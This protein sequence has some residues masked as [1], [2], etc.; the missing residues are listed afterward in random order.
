MYI[1]YGY[2]V[3]RMAYGRG[4]MNVC[5]TNPLTITKSKLFYFS[6]RTNTRKIFSFSVSTNIWLN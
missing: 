3:W 2:I 6:E 1:V 4:Y 5:H